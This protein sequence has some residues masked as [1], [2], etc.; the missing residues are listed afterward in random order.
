MRAGPMALASLLLAITYLFV[1]G[2]FTA[3]DVAFGLL[4]S[5]AMVV[6]ARDFV[7]PEGP[8]KPPLLGRLVRFPIFFAAVV[9][10]VS[11]GLWRVARLVAGAGDFRPGILVIRLP[12]ATPTGLVVF[13]LVQTLSPGSVVLEFRQAERELYFYVLGHAAPDEMREELSRFYRRWQRPVFP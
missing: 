9:A 5:V 13:A 6:A 10:S 3:W 2:S 7:L 4:I 11:I 1:V 8:P 12:D